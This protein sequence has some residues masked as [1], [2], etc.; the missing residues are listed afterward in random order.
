[1][2]NIL[3]EKN[4]GILTV[5]PEGQLDMPASGTLESFLG[6]RYDGAQQI[7]I[8]LAGVDYISSAGL[9]VIIQAYK[10]MKEKDG[11]LLRN[12]SDSIKDVLEVTGYIHI[13]KIEN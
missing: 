11:I 2:L 5:K 1:M 10:H 12:V 9:R 6:E 7:I 13:L 8:D 3:E 4:G